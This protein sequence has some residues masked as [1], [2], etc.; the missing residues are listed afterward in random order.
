M[1]VSLN[2]LTLRLRKI[3][4]PA[5]AAIRRGESVLLKGPP[6]SGKTMIARRLASALKVP[7]PPKQSHLVQAIWRIAGL[8]APQLLERPFRAPHHTCSI[9]GLVGSGKMMRP[10]ELSLAHMGVLLLDELPEFTRR[11][12]EAVAWSYQHKLVRFSGSDLHLVS[13]PA[14]F[15]LVGVTNPCPCGRSETTWKCECS[16]AVIDCYHARYS[17]LTF[18]VTVN[19]PMMDNKTTKG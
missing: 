15:A 17:I 16:Q 8:N 18:D 9:T 5:L 3:A 12:L 2:D 1:T 13:L 19:V 11:A 4:E 7:I 6:G 14:D 10:G